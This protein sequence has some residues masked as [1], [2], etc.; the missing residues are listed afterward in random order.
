VMTTQTPFGALILTQVLGGV[1]YAFIFVPLSVVLFRTVPQPAIP[2]ALALTRLVQQIG[3]SIGSAF[4]ATLLDR[5][6]VAAR[7]ALGSSVS[8]NTPS[9][10]EFIATHGSQSIATLNALV[11]SEASN[12]AAVNATQVFA[13]ATMAACVLPFLL[14]RTQRPVL[15]APPVAP[16]TRTSIPVLRDTI[17]GSRSLVAR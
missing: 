10:S 16:A 5:G 3:A 11:D 14:A 4:A 17:E 6:Y 8:L 7:T 1:G 9:V 15:Q 13:I 2:S 12:I